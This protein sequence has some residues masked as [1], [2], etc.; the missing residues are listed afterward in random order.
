MGSPVIVLTGA[1]TGVGYESALGAAKRGAHVVM[2][3]RDPQRG[4]QARAQVQKA[5]PRAKVELLLCDLASQRQVRRLAAELDA[6]LERIDVLVHN[7]GLVARERRLTEDGVETTFAVNHLAPFLLTTLLLPKLEAS[8]PA[9]VVV[10]ASQVEAR[11]SIHFDDLGL[12]HGFEPLRAYFQSKLANV[13]FTYALAR[14]LE[15]RG[16]TANC[17]HPGVLATNLLCDYMGRPRALSAAHRLTHPGPAQGAKVV[18]K[19]AFDPALEGR[20]GLYFHEGRETKSSAASCD[21]ALQE[22]LWAASEA[23]VAGTA[24]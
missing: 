6:R 4:E 17:A 9:R 23:L 24:S 21:R 1:N 8:Q 16:V 3:C 19:L 14:R 22:R 15:G 12:A 2:V 7:A 11:G 5:A 10:V 13:L 18:L 20:T